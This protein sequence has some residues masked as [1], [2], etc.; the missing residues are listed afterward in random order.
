MPQLDVAHILLIAAVAFNGILTGASLDQSIKQLPARRRIGV[1]AFSAYSR[2]A[3]LGNGIV[4]YAIIGVGA[5]L[6]T[7]AASVGAY[8][9]AASGSVAIPLYLAAL[10]SLLHSFTTTQ[11][12]PTLFRV[13]QVK[14]DAAQLTVIFDRF[15]RWQTLRAA[16][17]VATFGL[18]L[19]ALAAA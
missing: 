10:T 9:Q 16:L 1:I 6:L 12:A 13:R 8:L 11:T 5:A 19:W 4:W 2:A 3:D 15:E 14:D 17:Q 18:T 7:I